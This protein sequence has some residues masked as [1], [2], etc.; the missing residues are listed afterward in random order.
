MQQLVVI[1]GHL[2]TTMWKFAFETCANHLYDVRST[3]S[4]AIAHY[5]LTGQLVDCL[6]RLATTNNAVHIAISALSW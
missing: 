5:N 1:T 3:L 6:W 4:A 2:I